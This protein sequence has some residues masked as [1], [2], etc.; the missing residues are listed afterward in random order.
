[1]KSISL[2]GFLG[3]CFT[4]LQAE[5]VELEYAPAPPDNPLKGLAPYTFADAKNRFPH[6]MQFTY[7]SLK[8]FLPGPEQVDWTVLEETL[9]AV[10]AEGCQLIFR[11]VA[12][13]PGDGLK[14]PAW[15]VESG[16][17][18]TV[19]KGADGSEHHTPDYEHPAMRAALDAFVRQLGERYDGDPRI[20]FITAGLLG[21]WGEWHNYPRQ[22]LWASVETQEVVMKAFEESFSQTPILLRYPKGFN[23]PASVPTTNRGF[24]YHDDSF[25][26]STIRTGVPDDA[27]CFVALLEAA[28]ELEAWK[29]VPI[30]GELRPELWETSFTSQ[31]N[32]KAQGFQECA[33]QTHVSW[34]LDSG[35]FA[36]RFELS[37]ER[38]NTAIE[39]VQGIGY[40]FFISHV[41]REPNRLRLSV[42]NRGIAPFYADWPVELLREGQ[43]VDRFQ[44]KGILPGETRI[45]DS[46]LETNGELQLRVPNPMKGGKSL[47]FANVEQDGDILLLP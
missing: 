15:L 37:E 26:W 19:W 20:G 14:L 17:G 34:L 3:L 22:D 39:A 41:N 1:M 46:A 47:R 4:Q 8:D 32:P 9:E 21:S 33:E 23:D 28:E 2:F 29:E 45:W 43:V 35:L 40:E 12:E 10:Q 24:G 27:W 16:V 36:A 42:T 11:V 5:T 13:Y 7:F 18:V 30:G 31:P 38:K 25:D 44:L 6:S